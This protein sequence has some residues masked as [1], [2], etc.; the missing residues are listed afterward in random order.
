MSVETRRP[1][2]LSAVGEAAPLTKALAGVALV[3]LLVGAAVTVLVAYSGGFSS[4]LPVSANLAGQGNAV[5]PGDLVRY[6]DFDVG[7]VASGITVVG[8]GRARVDLH[9]RPSAAAEIPANVVAQ[10][11]PASIFGTQAVVLT[12]AAHPSAEHVHAHGVIAAAATGGTSLQTTTANLDEI[13][14]AL[15]PA[16]LSTALDAVAQ[17]VDGQGTRLGQALADTSQYLHQLQPALPALISDV[18]LVGTIAQQASGYVPSLLLGVRNLT[19]TAETVTAAATQL[20][21]LLRDADSAV[22]TGTTVVSENAA[23]YAS[24]AAHVLPLLT[25]VGAH[26]G[27]LPKSLQGLRQ[28]T[29]AW[30]SAITPNH[31]LQATIFLPVPDPYS[32][33]AAGALPVSTAAKLAADQAYHEYLDPATYTA[34]QC[35]RYGA[36]AG[37]NCGSAHAMTRAQQTALAQVGQ[38]LDGRYD[39]SSVTALLLGPVLAGATS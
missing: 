31:T 36:L 32:F 26:P 16:E 35:P 37:P 28:W 20:G 17:A 7:T 15:H 25:T 9:L 12:D 22:E 21:A 39:D 4:S 14:D 38:Q 34:S 10:V 1:R 19:V 3:V 11:Q 5:Q 29:T 13:L 8:P 33:V 23:T 30:T 24:L 18:S 27:A 6:R 2:A